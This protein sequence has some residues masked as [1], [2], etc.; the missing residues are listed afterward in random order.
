[1]IYNNEEDPCRT[2]YNESKKETI[3]LLI[4]KAKHD[5]YDSIRQQRIKSY[6]QYQKL[7]PEEHWGVLKGT[8]SSENDRSAG[9]SLFVA[10][11]DGQ[12]AGSVVLF[13]SKATAYEWDSGRLEYPEIRMLAVAPNFRGSGTG[14]ALVRYCIETSKAQGEKRIGLHTGSFMQDAMKL[15]ENIGFERAPELDFSPLD[16]GIVVFAYQLII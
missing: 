12:I 1:L 15:Y 4:R 7:L 9:A 16:D 8:L 11:I 10:E 5:E 2:L 14:K 3:Q 6:E 13:S